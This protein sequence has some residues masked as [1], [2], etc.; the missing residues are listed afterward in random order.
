MSE[1]LKKRIAAWSEGYVLGSLLCQPQNAL[2][3]NTQF[4]LH[5][6]EPFR[7]R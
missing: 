5:H 3:E 1:A 2:I 4:F 7:L 6:P